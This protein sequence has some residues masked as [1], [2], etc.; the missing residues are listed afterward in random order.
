MFS[1]VIPLYN[2]RTTIER[3]LRSVLAQTVQDFE[4]VVVDDGSTDGGA[5]VVRG[6][7]DPRIRLIHQANA[8]VSAARNRGIAEARH[9]LIA[10]LDADDE[11]LPDFLASIRRMA[12]QHP[13]AG[14][15]A[16]R[17][18]LQYGEKRQPAI[19]RGLAD[20]FEG[21]LEDYFAL[22][23]R[24]HPPI[25]ASAVCVRK[26]ALLKVGGFPVGITSGEDLLT[27][28]R[29]ACGE[30]VAY[31]AT[32]LAVFHQDEA[33]MGLRP[34]SRVPQSPDRVGAGLEE[35][36]RQHPDKRMEAY[37]A[38]WH[39]MRASCFLRLGMRRQALCETLN[40]LSC[41]VSPRLLAYLGLALLPRP[42][43]QRCFLAGSSARF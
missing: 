1:V 28:A 6:I 32:P 16:T 26:N 3:A 9:E 8:G 31:C 4:I 33:G 11:W 22:A 35:L 25:H 36:R 42:A 18:F 12:Q 40:G 15:Y 34:P 43:M 39:K 30:S 10:F 27:W 5:E 20:G 24:S 21:I 29:L 2:K 41:H 14:V 23:S 19:L 7:G 37:L 17:Y 38:L 13:E